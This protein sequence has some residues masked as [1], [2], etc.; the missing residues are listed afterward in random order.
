M[1]DSRYP[2]LILV[3]RRNGLTE[4]FDLAPREQAQLWREVT[5]A[6]ELLKAATQCRKINI[7]ALGNAVS[8]LHVHVIARNLD[9]HAGLGPVWG[10]R[11]TERYEATALENAIHRFTSIL[12]P[13]CPIS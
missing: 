8:Q 1:N 9:D 5:H 2:W 4:A 13:P 12:H 6:A 11:A 7:G 10:N 3:P